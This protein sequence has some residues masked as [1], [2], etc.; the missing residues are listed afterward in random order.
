MRQVY[1][2]T[3]RDLTDDIECITL[4]P[5]LKVYGVWS[6]TQVFKL[7]HKDSQTVF[8]IRLHCSKG[9]DR[10][11]VCHETSICGMTCTI[12]VCEEVLPRK[13]DWT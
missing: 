4:H 9:G 8:D 11:K 12:P 5:K 10:V 6:L 7:L 13:A 1:G 3:Y 2:E